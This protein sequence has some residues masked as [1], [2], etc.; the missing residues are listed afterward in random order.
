LN[1][2]ASRLAPASGGQAP[3]KSP[4]YRPAPTSVGF[5]IPPEIFARLRVFIDNLALTP[6]QKAQ[7]FTGFQEKFFNN[8]SNTIQVIERN[9]ETNLPTAM[10]E[11]NRFS[12]KNEFSGRHLNWIKFLAG[13]TV[14]GF[15]YANCRAFREDSDANLEYHHD[16]VQVVFPS[17]SPSKHG[18]KD[19]YIRDRAETWKALHRECPI[20]WLN[21]WLN[22]HLNTFRMLSFWELSFSFSQGRVR[23]E[24]NPFSI[25]HNNGDHNEKRVTR[26]I[27]ALKL[28][29]CI[30][31]L[32][33]LE[34]LLKTNYLTR[35]SCKTWSNEFNRN[36]HL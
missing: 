34:E 28:F 32:I 26:L 30:D 33:I 9:I 18:N 35:E 21:I 2:P 27:V 11:L 1:S 15:R 13:D 24:D 12:R 23:L 16:Y 17:W 3:F 36:S 25:L 8:E 7:I 4:A 29:E 5:R 22:M 20:L 19:L 31:L 6:Q 10:A 14:Q